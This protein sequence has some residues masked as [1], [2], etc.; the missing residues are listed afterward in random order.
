MDAGEVVP[1]HVEGYRRLMILD[2]FLRKAF[3]SRVNR[4]MLIRIVKLWRST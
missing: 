3:V 2:I 1:H 4:R